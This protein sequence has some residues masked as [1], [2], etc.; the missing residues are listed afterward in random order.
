M[1]QRQSN[2]VSLIM[3]ILSNNQNGSS[4]FMWPQMHHLEQ[5]S[6]AI[7]TAPQMW[8]WNGV[9]NAAIFA[10]WTHINRYIRGMTLSVLCPPP[11]SPNLN[12]RTLV[13]TWVSDC[14]AYHHNN[15]QPL[16]M[17]APTC[18]RDKCILVCLAR[19][20]R[21]KYKSTLINILAGLLL[22]HPA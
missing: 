4:T 20:N 10:A 12:N 9:N 8:C 22:K 13:T 19:R 16:I 6:Q 17:S 2:C 1:G 5:P 15:R 11:R 3:D 14:R 18:R 7:V 21:A